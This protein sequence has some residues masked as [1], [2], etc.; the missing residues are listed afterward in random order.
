[1]YRY[2]YLVQ[3]LKKKAKQSQNVTVRWLQPGEDQIFRYS[4]FSWL[5]DCCLFSLPGGWMLKPLSLLQSL[6]LQ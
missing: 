2:F 4:S 6:P 3:K 1:M 5:E